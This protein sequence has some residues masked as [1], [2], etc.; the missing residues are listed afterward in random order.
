MGRERL[1]EYE[2]AR[3]YIGKSVDMEK[4]EE[5]FTQNGYDY[6]AY[7]GNLVDV[8]YDKFGITN[9]LYDKWLYNGIDFRINATL[10]DRKIVKCSIF[11]YED[12]SG[13]G[14]GRPQGGEGSP[15][16][17]EIRIFKRIMEY[18]TKVE[19]K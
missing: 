9:A 19:G 18:V 14:C 3:S 5:V 12:S 7:C 11:K 16:Q 15:T 17:Q 13:G 10:E 4:F 2:I 8:L 1:D 6:I